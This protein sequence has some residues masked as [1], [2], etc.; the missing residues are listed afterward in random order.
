MISC[1]EENGQSEVIMERHFIRIQQTRNTYQL[2]L[3]IVALTV[4]I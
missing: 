2:I 1:L 3:D 4:M